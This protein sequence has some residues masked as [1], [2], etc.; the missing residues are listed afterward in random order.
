LENPF[1]V[2]DAGGQTKTLRTVGKK[3]SYLQSTKFGA[4][5]Q[6]FYVMLD[7]EGKPLAGS[8][9]YVKDVAEYIAFLQKGLANYNK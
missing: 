8:C 1:E 4:Y 6:P 7:N 5:A 3:W 9:G 2:E